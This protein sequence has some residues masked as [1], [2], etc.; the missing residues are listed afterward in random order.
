MSGYKQS[1]LNWIGHDPV[2]SQTAST[3][4]KSLFAL[5]HSLSIELT[6]G[7]APRHSKERSRTWHGAEL[8]EL[9][10]MSNRSSLSRIGFS[11]TRVRLDG[12]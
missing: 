3:S 2:V 10:D 4:R 7:P 6:W 8:E 5:S 11:T 1:F 9:E 12:F